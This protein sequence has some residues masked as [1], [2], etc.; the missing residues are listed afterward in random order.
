MPK[1][2]PIRLPHRYEVS[3]DTVQAPPHTLNLVRAKL[4]GVQAEMCKGNTVQAYEL[5]RQTQE[6]VNYE[7]AKK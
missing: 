6:F 1:P 7:L 5:L 3:P 4:E 2:E